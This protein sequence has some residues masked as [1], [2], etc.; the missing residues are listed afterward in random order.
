MAFDPL[1]FKQAKKTGVS[2]TSDH[3]FFYSD[4]LE[5]LGMT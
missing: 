5:R 1:T 2:D 3:R 4:D